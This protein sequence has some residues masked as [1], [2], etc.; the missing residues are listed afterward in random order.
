MVVKEN[1]DRKKK[2]INPNTQVFYVMTLKKRNA[3]VSSIDYRVMTKRLL[4][5]VKHAVIFLL[6]TQNT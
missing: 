4:V 2:R 5:T 1:P 3:L 6:E